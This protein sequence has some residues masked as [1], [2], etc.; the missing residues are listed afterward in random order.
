MLKGLLYSFFCILFLVNP[1]ITEIRKLYKK[2]S[3]SK[4]NAEAFHSKFENIANTDD[5]ILVAYKAASLTLMAK[6]AKGIKNK[7]IFFR[8]GALLL[9]SLIAKYPKDI[10]LRFIR[11]TIQENAPKIVKYKKNISEDKSLIVNGL[12]SLKNTALKTYIKS[13]VLQSKSFSD[14]EK[15]VI[16]KL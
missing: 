14:Q 5:K 10:E 2:A 11:L 16:S 7:K 3:L 9:E 13:Y 8:D 1:S 12:N 4:V 15:N 6:Y